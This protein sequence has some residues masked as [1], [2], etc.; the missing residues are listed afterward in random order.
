MG[1]EL[2]HMKGFEKEAALRE[3]FFNPDVRTRL[4]K[5]GAFM[6]VARVINPDL[7]AGAY[8]RRPCT[9]ILR[10]I[11][12]ERFGEPARSQ[13][14]DTDGFFRGNLYRSVAF[15]GATYTIEGHDRVIGMV[16][17]EV[18]DDEQVAR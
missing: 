14:P 5:W 3:M 12:Y 4:A 10:Y 16:Y 18:V 1:D 17:F 11:G 13:E 8:E 2:K 6:A 15:N 7:C 9:R